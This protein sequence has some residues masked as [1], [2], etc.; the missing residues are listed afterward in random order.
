MAAL[1]MIVPPAVALIWIIPNL[2]WSVDYYWG[3]DP[4]YPGLATS[5][6]IYTVDKLLLNNIST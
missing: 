3:I 5:I 6:I 2:F 4:I 1:A